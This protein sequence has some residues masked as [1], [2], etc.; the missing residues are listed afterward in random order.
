MSKEATSVTTYPLDTCKYE[1]LETSG[2]FQI[3]LSSQRPQVN[4]KRLAVSNGI[5]CLTIP[6]YRLDG[7]AGMT[8]L[9]FQPTGRHAS[10]G[11]EIWEAKDP[12]EIFPPLFGED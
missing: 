1:V 6:A 12:G 9:D 10:D 8:L 2:G 3:E 5:K 7:N 4:G 11:V